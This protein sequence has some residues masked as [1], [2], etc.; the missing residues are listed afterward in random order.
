MHSADCMSTRY[1]MKLDTAWRP[2]S[3]EWTASDTRTL[4]LSIQS[5]HVHVLAK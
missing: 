2:V 5:W 3:P 1:A 4:F